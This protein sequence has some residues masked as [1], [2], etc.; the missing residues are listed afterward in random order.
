MLDSLGYAD[1][2]RDGYSERFSVVAFNPDNTMGSQV[3]VS[4]LCVPIGN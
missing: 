3:S 4:A 1:A 2:D